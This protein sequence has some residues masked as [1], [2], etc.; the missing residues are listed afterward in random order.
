[1]HLSVDDRAALAVRDDTADDGEARIYS[2]LK[3]MH[4]PLQV[5]QCSKLEASG[6][7]TR[8]VTLLDPAA[9]GLNVSVFI[10]IRLEK[11][12]AAALA[13]FESAICAMPEVM[14]CYLMTGDSDYLLRVVVAD[15]PALQRF[16]V[17]RLTTIAGIAT[18]RSSCALKQVK[19]KTALPL[20]LPP[21]GARRK[22]R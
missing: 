12:V 6:L 1:M 19:F 17:E 18:R 15:L 22:G 16:I 8:Y 14:E 10:E 2:L 13:R 11:Q 20:S 21:R 7:I 3:E 5:S 9:V 4:N